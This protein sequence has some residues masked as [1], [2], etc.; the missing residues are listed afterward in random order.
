MRFSASRIPWKNTILVVEVCYE[1]LLN[2]STPLLANLWH[3][4][5]FTGAEGGLT[6]I[7]VLAIAQIFGKQKQLPFLLLQRVGILVS[8][9]IQYDI[10]GGI[11]L[12]ITAKYL[13]TG[14]SSS[15]FLVVQRVG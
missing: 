4:L 15:S 5:V 14:Y 12:E 1:L 13:L 8:A 10:G 7:L 6:I 9:G 3:F 11:L 2:I